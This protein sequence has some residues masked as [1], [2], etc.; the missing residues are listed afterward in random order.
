[1]LAAALR[2]KGNSPRIFLKR[3]TFPTFSLQADIEKARFSW[4]TGHFE[5]MFAKPKLLLCLALVLSSCLCGCSTTKPIFATGDGAI[6][7][8]KLPIKFAGYREFFTFVGTNS[9]NEMP[10]NDDTVFKLAAESTIEVVD[11][12]Y[13]Q[14][15]HVYVVEPHYFRGIYDEIRG[16]Q[17]N[18]QYYVL[19]PLAADNA[20]LGGFELVGILD[21]NAYTVQH[22][23]GIPRFVCN[24]HLS[25]REH[26]ESIYEWNGKKFERAK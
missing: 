14:M 13:K 18:G 6:E 16:A 10:I 11:L 1:L 3:E 17:G 5:R 24:W 8:I 25:A 7:Q 4:Q 9:N 26:P 22:V 21:G 2:H 15:P 12:S 23:N 19:R 20:V